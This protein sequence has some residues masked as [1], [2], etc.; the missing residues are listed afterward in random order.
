MNTSLRRVVLLA[1]SLESSTFRILFLEK[2]QKKNQPLPL[3]YFL[4]A[5]FK[6]KKARL[7]LG[8]ADFIRL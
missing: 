3:K 4:S 2:R 8:N 1:A 6:H 7:G 5:Y